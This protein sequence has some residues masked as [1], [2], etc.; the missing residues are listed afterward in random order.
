MMRDDRI[1]VIKHKKLGVWIYPGGHLEENEV[2]TDTAVREALEEIGC[3]TEIIDT[4]P[5]KAI[6][7]GDVTKLPQPLAML[8]EHVRYKDEPHMH[9]DMIYLAKAKGKPVSI[10]E[11]ESKEIRWVAEADVDG[12]DTYPSVKDVLHKAFSLYD[13]LNMVG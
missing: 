8:Y 2:P 1:A 3:N 10:A 6:K 13:G 7:I 12:L 11:S 9:F 4:V 5:G